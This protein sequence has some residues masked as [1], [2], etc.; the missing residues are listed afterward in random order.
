MSSCCIFNDPTS[1]N[2]LGNCKSYDLGQL[3]KWKRGTSERGRCLFRAVVRV[4]TR[5]KPCETVKIT[6]QLLST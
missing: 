1:T 4:L 5:V 3:Q 6:L 2:S